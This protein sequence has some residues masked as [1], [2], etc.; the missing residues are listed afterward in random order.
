M[1]KTKR[2]TGR[3]QFVRGLIEQ[4]F[5]IRSLRSSDAESEQ[6][7]AAVRAYQRTGRT[8]TPNDHRHAVRQALR[9]AFEAALERSAIETITAFGLLNDDE[10]DNEVTNQVDVVARTL[11]WLRIPIS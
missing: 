10:F 9:G 3:V 5:E 2:Q 1:R 8:V 6:H 4:R 11:D 7:A